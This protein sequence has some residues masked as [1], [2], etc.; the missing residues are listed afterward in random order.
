MR[1]GAV[2]AGLCLV[3]ATAVGAVED[4]AAVLGGRPPRLGPLQ[5][6][7]RTLRCWRAEEDGPEVAEDPSS[8]RLQA[9]DADDAAG[10]DIVTAHSQVEEMALATRLRDEFL[11]AAEARRQP[12]SLPS[13]YLHPT[14]R[15]DMARRGFANPVPSA[16]LQGNR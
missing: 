9:I 15:S 11:R 14:A 7:T 6:N 1:P 13:W 2:V 12:T 5:C 8:R 10:G 3:A 16:E 4:P